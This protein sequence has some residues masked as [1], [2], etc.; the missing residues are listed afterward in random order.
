MQQRDD[1]GVG[2]SGC[3]TRRG[4]LHAVTLS[5]GVLPAADLVMEPKD[6]AGGVRHVVAARRALREDDEEP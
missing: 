6:S 3:D 2:W 5:C 1:L 4:S